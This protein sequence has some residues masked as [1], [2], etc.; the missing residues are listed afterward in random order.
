MASFLSA[1]R[2]RQVTMGHTYQL[3]AR[4]EAGEVSELFRGTQ[5][6]NREVTLKLFAPRLSDPEYGKALVDASRKVGALGH[7][8]ILHYEDIGTVEH[9]LCCVRAHV[10]GYHL[11]TALSRLQ[12]KE[13]VL[14]AP[15]ALQIGVEV[16]RAV[17][18]AHEAGLVH[19]ALTPANIQVSRDG[20]V[21]VNDFMALWAMRQAASMRA[22]ADRGR[23]AYRAP[24]V[25]KGA[26]PDPAADVY[27]V[28][29]ILYELLTLREVAASRGGGVSTRR[30]V[31]TPPSR[32]DRRVNARLDPLI[33]RALDPLKSRRHKNCL[34]MA[35]SIEAFLAAQGGVPGRAE[36]G[37]FVAEL[38]P[39]EVNLAGSSSDLPFKQEFGLRP[40]A[41]GVSIPGLKIEVSERISYSQASIDI[42]ELLSD[43]EAGTQELTAADNVDQLE[44]T[45]PPEPPKPITSWDAPPGQLDP[46]VEK[47]RSTPGRAPLQPVD[48]QPVDRAELDAK[49]KRP[50][51]EQNFVAKG[52]SRTD[53][54]TNP[55]PASDLLGAAEEEDESKDTVPGKAKKIVGQERASKIRR[56]LDIKDAAP[57][58]KSEK[59][60]WYP[61]YE[62]RP[63]PPK[64]KTPFSHW[65]L[66]IF[67]AAIAAVLT[68]LGASH[69]TGGAV[70]LPKGEKGDLH[71]VARPNEP[72]PEPQGGKEPPKEAV[73]EPPKPVHHAAPPPPPR[74][75]SF[76]VSVEA[77]LPGATVRI[78]NGTPLPLPLNNHAVA[79]GDHEL[80]VAARGH[81]KRM[82]VTEALTMAPCVVQTV[83]LSKAGAR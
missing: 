32:L 65:G 37:K 50:K 83:L 81:V 73:K 31:L 54:T 20:K 39:N 3:A 51:P 6:R 67:M 10:E 22:L 70:E 7:P 69:K 59:P 43:D 53:V 27:S 40:V 55:T 13:V 74:P 68:Y 71:P 60:A 2:A 64:P 30:D 4:V 14:T 11:G 41:E 44:V 79:P 24:E 66:A 49:Q 75:K 78:D 45:A 16:M 17:G 29:A 58:K 28:G 26:E 82:H 57:E 63:P 61:K 77:D 9:Q 8:A 1:P 18:T 15:V 48:T 56:P 21:Y 47:L 52:D 76:C 46:A 36:I 42:S 12:S 72:K 33:M 62:P 35:E 34:E 25:A 5:N 19:G 38:F 23:Q 80:V